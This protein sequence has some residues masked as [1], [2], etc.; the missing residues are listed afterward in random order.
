[1][2]NHLQISL[3]F[4]HKDDMTDK[5]ITLLAGDVGG[6]KTNLALYK[7]FKNNFEIITE[8]S[9]QSSSYPT[10]FT[11]INLFISEN[12]LPLPNRMCIG[13]A[14]PIIHGKAEITNLSWEIDIESI[15]KETG[16]KEIH[17]LNDLEATAY[18]LAALTT[19]DI[20]TLQQGDASVKGNI[21]IIAPGTGLGEAGLYWDG[22]S[23][24]PFPTE[25]GHCDFC[26][27]T[28]LDI[29]LL[30]FLQKKYGVVS[31]EKAVA[32]PGIHDIYIFLRGIRNLEE[33][34]WL[35]DALKKDDPSAVISHA[36]VNNK[37]AVC[38]EAMEIFVRYLARESSN[39]VLKMRATGGLFLAGGIPAKIAPLLQK[40]NYYKNYLDCDRM[41][42]LLQQVPIHIITNDKTA[43]MG[44]AWY[45]AYGE[46]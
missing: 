15:R 18:G 8:K 2:S 44:A 24:Y 14:G 30:H 28:D 17:L 13:V 38:V 4:A 37:D 20:I 10:L 6:T 16:I 26:P 19:E 31:W 27:R 45:G 11:I 35:A 39:L 46:M 34:V 43:M 25:G 22:K 36:A 1:M 42:N 40:E 5:E 23:Y 21:A 12:K 29:D 9:Y 33:P 3:A 41:Q 32:G 7:I